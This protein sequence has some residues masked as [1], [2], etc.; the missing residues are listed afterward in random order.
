M[1]DGPYKTLKMSRPWKRL[2]KLAANP[3]H[4]TA[5][6]AEA[7]RP[8]LLEDWNSVR[9]A[10]AQQV[11]AA[12]GDNERGNLFLEVTLAETQRLRANASNPVEALLADQAHDAARDGL[13]GEAAYE[14]AIKACLDDRALQ[15]ARQMEEHYLCEQSPDTGR[16]RAKLG[17]AIRTA[18]TDKMAA[19]I[20]KGVGARTLAPK[21]DRTGLDEGVPL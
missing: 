11:R 16:L 9:P 19:G 7:L 12:L 6:V 2:A 17:E 1:S 14:Q 21:V 15:R 8:A 13:S 10:F 20:A 4:S 3:A 18:E 5:E